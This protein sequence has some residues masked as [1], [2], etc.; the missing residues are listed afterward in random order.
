M[1]ANK[2][3]DPNKIKPQLHMEYWISYSDG[4]TIGWE[5]SATY[6]GNY[7]LETDGPGPEHIPSNRVDGYM[8]INGAGLWDGEKWVDINNNETLHYVIRFTGP[9]TDGL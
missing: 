8:D 7:W 6:Y 3:I 9:I 1:N 4:R 5:T 2:W